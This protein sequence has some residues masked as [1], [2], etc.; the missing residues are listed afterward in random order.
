MFS[1]MSHEEQLERAHFCI[2]RVGLSAADD[3][4]PSEISGGM[5]KRV[6]I[7]RAIALNPKYLFATSLT[8]V[9]TPARRL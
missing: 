1:K 9:L 2:K 3:K 4:F 8:P 7:A 5:Q 6:A